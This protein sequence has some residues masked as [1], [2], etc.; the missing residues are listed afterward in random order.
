MG[1]DEKTGNKIDDLSGKAKEGVGKV[2]GNERLKA[3]GE[4]D[5]AKT[6]VKEGVRKVKEG[7]SG[8]KDSLEDDDKKDDKK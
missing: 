1:Y 6:S 5:Q 7:L 3:E 4:T 8:M 2:T